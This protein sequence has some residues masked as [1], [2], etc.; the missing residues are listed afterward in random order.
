MAHQ[1]NP[2]CDVADRLARIFRIQVFAEREREALKRRAK[3]E[4]GIVKDGVVIP[5]K[6]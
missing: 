6:H 4:D 3:A 1:K 5:R 2:D